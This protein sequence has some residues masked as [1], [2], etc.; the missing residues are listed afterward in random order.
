MISLYF[1][2][3]RLLVVQNRLRRGFARD[4]SG[5]KVREIAGKLNKSLGEICIKLETEA[6]KK[7]IEDHLQKLE[8]TELRFGTPDGHLLPYS[9]KAKD[10]RNISDTGAID[11]I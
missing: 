1:T 3:A 9:Y 11:T 8:G 6:L 10:G 5:L 7:Q 2:A 4:L